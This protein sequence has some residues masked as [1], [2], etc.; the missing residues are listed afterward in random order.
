MI[1]M[2]HTRHSLVGVLLFLLARPSHALG[3]RATFTPVQCGRFVAELTNPVNDST[4]N[5]ALA[6]IYD[7]PD[8]L[9]PTLAALWRHLPPDSL[10]RQLLYWASGH[11]HDD[12]LYRQVVYRA[13]DSQSPDSL[14]FRALEV[15]VTIADPTLLITVRE[16]PGAIFADTGVTVGIGGFSHTFVRL[17]RNPI[18]T[19][20]RDSI[21][22]LFQ[23][24]ATT[25]SSARV[26]RVAKRARDWLVYP[27]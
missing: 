18:P 14:R 24:L 11:V 17:G 9:G 8:E 7:C 3:Q 20:A 19:N 4:W 23:D 2:G 16:L 12:S 10:K 26:R 15:L 27:R 13:R 25:D 6:S 22:A 1:R 5:L 21:L